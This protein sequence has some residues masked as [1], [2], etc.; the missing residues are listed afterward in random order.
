MSKGQSI[1][2]VTAEPSQCHLLKQD[3]EHI[4]RTAMNGFPQLASCFMMLS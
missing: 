1:P 3:F 2:G 4:I